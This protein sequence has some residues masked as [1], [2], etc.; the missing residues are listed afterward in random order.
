[1]T[2]PTVEILEAID[3]YP[4][5]I[6]L[7]PCSTRAGPRAALRPAKPRPKPGDVV[8]WSEVEDGGLYYRDGYPCKF[9]M[10]IRRQVGVMSS[11][12]DSDIERMIIGHFGE[13]LSVRSDEESPILV[14]RDLGSDP[15]AWRRAMR[16]WTA[17]GNKHAAPTI[18]SLAAAYRY[19]SARW[20]RPG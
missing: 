16:E 5:L 8:P 19:A 12:D 13:D 3:G 14:A 6:R 4:V 20:M 2:T 1:M 9:G 17:N 15:E 10:V 11:D 18:A 7:S